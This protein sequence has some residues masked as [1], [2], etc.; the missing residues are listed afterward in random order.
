MDIEIDQL[1]IALKKTLD[2][3]R[4]YNA[5]TI[6]IDEDYYWYIMPEQVYNPLADPKDL[7]MGQLEEDYEFLMNALKDDRLVVCHL[8][9]L[10][11]LLRYI[12]DTF[13]YTDKA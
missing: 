9:N 8:K 11:V 6:P 2:I 13:S 7:G 4:E 1:E 5:T 12:A 10:S 3:L